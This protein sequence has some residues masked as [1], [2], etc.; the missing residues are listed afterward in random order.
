MT[1]HM[2][3]WEEQEPVFSALKCQKWAVTT[4]LIKHVPCW[5]VTERSTWSSRLWFYHI[6]QGMQHC[7]CSVPEEEKRKAAWV[8]TRYSS[9]RVGW[10]S[11]IF[12]ALFTIANT[13]FTSSKK[14]SDAN[15]SIL[16]P[17]FLGN[18]ALHPKCQITFTSFS[19]L[20]KFPEW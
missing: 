13:L 11:R 6:P 4:C 3:P 18:I 14:P 9:F 12:C 17:Y 2:W 5:K 10:L 15:Y 16:V 20:L 8:R 19:V 7:D 1:N